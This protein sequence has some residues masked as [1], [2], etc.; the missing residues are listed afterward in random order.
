[1]T[2][3]DAGASTNGR[4]P[5]G[6]ADRKISDHKGRQPASNAR[7]P[8]VYWNTSL[9]CTYCIYRENKNCYT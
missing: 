6:H 5:R 9:H 7:Q 1:M 3:M 2:K 4:R 8:T